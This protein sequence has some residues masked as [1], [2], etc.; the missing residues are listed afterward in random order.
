M[1]KN[2]ILF[3]LLFSLSFNQTGIVTPK[4]ESAM[5]VWGNISKSVDCDNCSEVFGGRM[6]YMMEN[7]LELGLSY[8]TNDNDGIDVEMTA[9]Y[10]QYHLKNIGEN[11][12][13]SLDSAKNIAI[14]LGKLT[15]S[16]SDDFD[17]NENADFTTLSCTLYN[18]NL[19]HFNY[20]LAY[21][22]GLNF[23]VII[24]ITLKYKQ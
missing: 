13:M 23:I 10:F 20:G 8:A 18:N 22:M 12:N 14:G 2:M 3:T 15:Y 6:S 16:G 7:G 9:F 21:G 4:G 1:K 17:H 11:V 24:W 5:G 19:F